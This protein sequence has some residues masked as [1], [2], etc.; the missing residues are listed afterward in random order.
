[1]TE[2]FGEMRRHL[3]GWLALGVGAL[4]LSLVLL[5]VF[6]GPFAP[7][8][9]VGVT[10]GEIAG[11]IRAS[12]LRALNGEPQPAPRPRGWDIDRV[13]MV[14]APLLGVG[15]IL[16]AVVSS[17]RR[18]PWQFSAYGVALGTAAIAFQFVWW[19]ALVVIGVCLLIV[20]IQNIGGILGG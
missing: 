9:S 8:P 5:Q 11:D 20:I 3:W 2:P 12:A 14:L 15:A 7:R 6:G 1:M 16:L 10:I 19:L 4:A 13:L 17:L 18:D